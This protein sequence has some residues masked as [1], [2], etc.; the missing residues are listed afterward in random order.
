MVTAVRV[1]G[2]PDAADRYI[3][4]TASAGDVVVTADIPLA[5]ILVAARVIV[6]DPRGF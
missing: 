3:A 6:I 4:T 1:E 5:A 2:S